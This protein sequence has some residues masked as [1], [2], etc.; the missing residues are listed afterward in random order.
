MPYKLFDKDGLEKTQHDLQDKGPW[1][2]HGASKEEI[3]VNNYGEQFSI[4]IN[5]EKLTNPYA[6][7]L[8]NTSKTV[9]CD[10]KTQNTPFFQ[11]RIRYDIDPQY[12]VTFNVKDYNRYSTLYPSIEIYFWVYWEIVKFQGSTAIEV[13]PME[14]VWFIP[15]QDLKEVIKISP[16]HTYQQR[17]GDTRGNALDS[18][19]LDLQ[20]PLF[21]KII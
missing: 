19:V 16:K 12:A 4:V 1:C 2:L 7:D 10:L 13:Q 20:N 3:F 15:F 14:G 21:T 6:P 8:L 18:Y 11:A 9:V 5:P 17:V